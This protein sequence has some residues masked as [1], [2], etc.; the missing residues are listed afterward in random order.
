VTSFYLKKGETMSNQDCKR[1]E[2]KIMNVEECRQNVLITLA[3]AG[4]TLAECALGELNGPIDYP[5]NIDPIQNCAAAIANLN[6]LRATLLQ[7]KA[8]PRK[9][10]N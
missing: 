1:N 8:V 3:R 7:A 2:G 9:D 5:N 4:Q 10:L 6:E